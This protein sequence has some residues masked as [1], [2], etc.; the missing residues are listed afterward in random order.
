MLYV[1]LMT[2]KASSTLGRKES[3]AR[4]VNWKY[5]EGMKVLGEYWVPS[6]DPSVVLIAETES[7][8]AIY[9]AMEDWDDVFEFRVFPAITAEVGIAMAREATA[10]AVA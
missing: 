4:R 1:T 5:P 7:L 2:R 8:A 6:D 10:T 9:R 3:R